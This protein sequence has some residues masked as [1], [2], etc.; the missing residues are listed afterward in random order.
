MLCNGSL[1]NWELCTT[2]TGECFTREEHFY[3]GDQL[4]ICKIPNGC[5]IVGLIY[6]K[7]EK[8]KKKTFGALAF[9]HQAQKGIKP[10]KE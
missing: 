2:A 8:K 9:L 10:S 5:F 7:T 4:N 3:F 6:K 1:M